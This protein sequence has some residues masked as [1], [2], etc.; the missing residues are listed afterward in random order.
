MLLAVTYI[1]CYLHKGLTVKLLKQKNNEKFKSLTGR[2]Y[3]GGLCLVFGLT[4]SV[5][6]QAATVTDS[7]IVNEFTRGINFDGST[8]TGLSQFDP[9]LGTLTGITL[10][11]VGDHSITFDLLGFVDDESS[12]HMIAGEINYQ[13]SISVNLPG[14]NTGILVANEVYGAFFDCT[15]DGATDFACTDSFPDSPGNAELYDGSTV[16]DS[17]ALITNLSNNGLLGLFIGT[18]DVDSA[19]LEIGMFAFIDGLQFFDQENI[20]IEDLAG[21][22]TLGPTTVTVEY[23]FTPA[24]TI[25]IPAA[26]WLFGSA[27]VGLAGIKRRA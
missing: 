20:T 16:N 9:S 18:G 12:P 15:S 23:E 2:H 17:T 25:P 8:V 6:T 13:G 26:A 1:E 10:S 7:V 11:A 22:F 27:L 4:A 24:T 5:F 19:A 3:K 14:S 21:E